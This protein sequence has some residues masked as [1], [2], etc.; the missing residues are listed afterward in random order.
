MHQTGA[1]PV[2]DNCRHYVMQTTAGGEKLERCKLGANQQLPFACPDGCVFFEARSV[3]SAGWQV[4]RDDR[5]SGP[6]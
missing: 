6:R 4:S 2:N 1:V 3:S 5:S